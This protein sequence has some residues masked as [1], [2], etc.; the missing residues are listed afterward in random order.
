MAAENRKKQKK[1]KFTISK[2]VRISI[3]LFLIAG[4]MAGGAIGTAVLA[5]MD[6]APVIDP[7]TIMSNLDQTSSIYDPDGNL[8]EKILAEELR[9]VVSIKQ[10]PK[11]LLDAFIAIEDERFETHPGVDVEGIAG[12]LLDNFKSGGLRG[13]STITQQLVK[14]VYLN[15][16]VKLT[17]KITEAYLALKMET[18]LSKDQILEA[19]LNRNYFGQNAYGVQE[20]SR[21]FFSKDV[22]DLTIAESAMLAGIIKSTTRFQPFFRVKPEDFDPSKHYEVGQIEVLGEKFIAVYNEESEVRQNLVLSQMLRLGKLTQQEYDQAVAQDIKLSLN[23]E[24]KKPQNITS[25][26][27]D[28]IKTQAVEAMVD[29]LGYTEDRK[30]VV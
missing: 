23:P 27:A 10:M 29:K 2:L 19:Y 7:T 6:D 18:I 30:S 8:I 17:R 15:N 3:L 12:A 11:H 1:A 22:Q 28:M 9:T 21:T 13:A 4:I 14:N 20:A 26:F 16:E 24:Q 25:Y 5:I